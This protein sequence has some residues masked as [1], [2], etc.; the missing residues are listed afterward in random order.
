[1][2]RLDCGSTLFKDDWLRSE[3]GKASP[4]AQK[5]I[6]GK[7]LATIHGSIEQCLRD[8]MVRGFA[9]QLRLLDS[10]LM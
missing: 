5:E 1:M 4:E 8:D 2:C 3:I 7:E 6:E 9:F 10:L